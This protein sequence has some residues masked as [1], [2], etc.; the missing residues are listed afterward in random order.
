MKILQVNK[1]LYP[2]GGSESYMFELSKGL[3]EFGHEVSFWGMDD[4]ENIVED[5]FG[6]FARNVDFSSQNILQKIIN[7]IATI[8]SRENAKKIEYILDRFKPDVVHLHNYNFQLTPSI[9]PQI[10]KRGIKVVYTAHDS[11][12]VCP[13]HRLYNF[14]RN[15]VCL[16]CID[17]NFMNCIKDRCFDSSLLKSVIGSFESYLYHGLNYYNRYIDLVISPSRFLGDLVGRQY[18]GRIE[19]IPNFVEYKRKVNSMKENYVLYFGRISEE[20]GIIDILHLFDDMKINLKIIGAGPDVEKIAET[21]YVK[22]L[23]PKYNDELFDYIQRAKL[24]IQPSKGFENCPM[25][26]IESFAC[27]TPVVGPNHSGF[28]ELIIDGKNG[29]L[30]D[31]DFENIKNVIMDIFGN[32]KQDL[33]DNCLESYLDGYTKAVHIPKII[34]VY[35]G[36]LNEGI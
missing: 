29:F 5:V 20:K 22:Y 32:Y 14:Q 25:T 6:C 18:R 33:E 17:G 4:N 36:L 13:Y 8:Y 24:V 19:V 2:K 27:G 35:K 21:K 23:G 7:S 30:V 16:K 1:F 15:M 34:N 26:I 10:Q 12:M 3:M 11:Q 28:M 9:L 31:F